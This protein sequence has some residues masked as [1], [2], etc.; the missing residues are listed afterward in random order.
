MA[1][2]WSPKCLEIANVM[3][4]VLGSVECGVQRVEVKC[5]VESMKCG[6]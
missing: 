6:V 2:S 4:E 1:V 5:G 3:A